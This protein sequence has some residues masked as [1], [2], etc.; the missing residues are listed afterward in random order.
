MSAKLKDAPDRPDRGVLTDTEARLGAERLAL[1][2]ALTRTRTIRSPDQALHIHRAEGVL[3]PAAILEDWTEGKR[4]ALLRR[5]L[6]DPATYGRVRFHHRSVQEYL[7]AQRLK[8]L[9][10]KGMSTKALFRLLF[11]ERY[12]VEV[13]FPS[14]RAIAAWLA[15]WDDAV[16]RELI[17]GTGSASAGD[18]ERSVSMRA[19]LVRAFVGAGQAAGAPD[20]RSTDA[21]LAHPEL[22]WSSGSFGA[23]GQQRDVREPL[24]EMIRQAPSTVAPTAARRGI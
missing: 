6:F 18:P 2:L 10:E 12:G 5:A 15:L 4:Q 11:G 1:A 16:R 3:E 9:R 21:R 20:I 17:S 7:A 8:A 14:M 24:I 22:A 23:K 13:V 19:E